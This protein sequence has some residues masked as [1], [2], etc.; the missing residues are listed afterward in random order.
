MG[1]GSEGFYLAGYKFQQFFLLTFLF[2]AFQEKRIRHPPLRHSCRQ[3]TGLK[4]CF[5]LFS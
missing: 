4:L 5:Y 2:G 1:L 3:Q